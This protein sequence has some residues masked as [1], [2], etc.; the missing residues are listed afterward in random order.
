MAV[1]GS[2]LLEQKKWTEA[3][4]ALRECLAIREKK[5]P[6]AWTIFN[7][8]SMLGA[9]LLGQARSASK[10]GDKEALARAS[11]FYRDAEPPLLK[12]YDGL[13]QRA[14]KIP[15]LVRTTRLTE[16]AERLVQ[17]Y[18]A[19]EKKDEAA[20]WRKELAALKSK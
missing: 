15:E 16:A 2:N 8:Q 14:A 9:A 19:Q 3:E 4:A 20:K 17:L 18:D 13:K 6:D 10:D 7:A 12:G 11:G 5:E 1:L